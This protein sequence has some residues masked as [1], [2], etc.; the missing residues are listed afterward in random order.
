MPELE[1]CSG[2][3][4]LKE[5]VYKRATIRAI[6]RPA[7]AQVP[8]FKTYPEAEKVELP[9]NW[10]L[11][12]ARITPL[13]QNR[14]SLRRYLAEPIKFEELA[15]LLWASQGITAKSGVYSFRTAPSG[16]ALYPVETYFS[17]NFVEDLAPGLYHFDVENFSLDRLSNEDSAAA[18]AAACLDQKFMAQ[19][20]VSFLWSSI[21]RR[22]MTKYG[23]RGLRYVLLDAGHIC[24]NL[25]V[26]AEA[27]GCGGCPVAA[28]YDDEV[29][30]LLQLDPGEESIVYAAAVGK[31]EKAKGTKCSL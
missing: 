15:F 25:L 10:R 13:L 21:F 17:A 8:T 20:A 11:A 30:D 24:Q 3:I 7:I 23:N 29:N 6:K 19:S 28:F 26:A 22:C 4:Y 12:E 18:V 1:E 31:K 27:I 2:Y 5:T 9:R 14:R 16:G